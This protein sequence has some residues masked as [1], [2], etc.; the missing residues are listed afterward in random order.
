[1]KAHKLGQEV[2]LRW[3]TSD[4]IKAAIQQAHDQGKV[5]HRPRFHVWDSD[6]QC[7]EPKT[8]VITCKPREGLVVKNAK[9]QRPLDLDL[10]RALAFA[11]ERGTTVLPVRLAE[12]APSNSR[13][14]SPPRRLKRPYTHDEED[15]PAP[16]RP[17]RLPDNVRTLARPIG[18]DVLTLSDEDVI[19]LSDD[20]VDLNP[21]SNSKDEAQGT[22]AA[23]VHAAAGSSRFNPILIG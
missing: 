17:E 2:Q 8:D 5:G 16:K 10:H 15:M 3:S 23:R 14:P 1:M 9:V 4:D 13:I 6:K 20:T 22:V 21:H 11:P 12:A 19:S 7:W 18:D